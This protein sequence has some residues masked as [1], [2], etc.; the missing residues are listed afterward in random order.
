MVVDHRQLYQH[1][2]RQQRLVV[3]HVCACD[4]MMKG[5]FRLVV[6]SKAGSCHWLWA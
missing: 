2:E 3:G 1:V 5:I 4:G 6:C